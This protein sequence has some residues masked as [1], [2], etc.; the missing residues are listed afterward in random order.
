MQI[1]YATSIEEDASLLVTLAESN[2]KLPQAETIRH[3][4]CN[5]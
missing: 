5:A 1:H 2:M 4:F 3:I